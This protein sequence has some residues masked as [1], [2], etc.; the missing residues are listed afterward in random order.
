MLDPRVVGYFVAVAEAGSVSRAAQRVLVAQPSLS[1]QLR[2][3]EREL[4]VQL[5]I[6]QG[7]ALRLSTAGRHFLPIARDLLRRNELAIA[8]T[9]YRAGSGALPLTVGTSTTTLVDVVAPFVAEIDLDGVALLA[10]VQD[11]AE[12]YRSL[13]EG[14]A[15]LAL[16]NEPSPADYSTTL[17]IRFPI[18]AYVCDDHSWRH[19]DA[20]SLSDLATAPLITSPASGTN[21]VLAAMS[22]AGLSAHVAHEVAVPQ[23]AQALAASGHGIAVL[24]DDPR[25]GLQALT[26]TDRGRTL[27]VPMFASWDRSHY[28]ADSIVRTVELLRTYCHQHWT[29]PSDAAE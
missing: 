12:A 6:R 29:E 25:F 27:T 28:A 8:A 9:R 23:I 7:G 15:D 17:I 1:R 26:I 16:T 22:E 14:R 19:R 2:A 20:V 10:R 21:T 3:L 11:A 13:G 24:S 18:Y 4:Q 5:F